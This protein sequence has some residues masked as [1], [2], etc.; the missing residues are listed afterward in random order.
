MGDRTSYAPGTF[1]W[2][3]LV[4][5]D[6][7]AAKAFYSA[8]LGW[9]YDDQPVGD[10]QVYSMAMRDGKHV[11]ALY[12]DAEQSP[13]WNCY[14]TVASADDSTARARAAGGTVLTE[15]FDV[16]EVG[17][18]AVVAD[19]AGASIFM[20][21]P[22]RHIG[23]QLVNAPGSLTW[24]DLVT[25]DPDG[26]ERFYGELFGW[27]FDELP[28]AEGY[29][30]IKNGDRMNGGVVPR[31]EAPAG[32]IPY[33]GHEDVERAIA[34]VP[35]LGGQVLNGPVQMAQGAIGVF[36]DPQGAPFALWTGWYED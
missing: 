27:T 30:V 9:D 36:C 10:E 35:G 18:M 11:A 13:H 17:R 26:A 31:D 2:T 22:R 24:N 19:P 15:P 28:D 29:R 12:R 4:T 33:F 32:W 14:V 16:M 23:A 34:D 21:E 3:E 5:T 1:S 8:L 6:P 25:P 7:D 20:W